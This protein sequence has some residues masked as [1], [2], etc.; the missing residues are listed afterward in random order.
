MPGSVQ[1]V[2]LGCPV[3]CR[4][5]LASYV[6]FDSRFASEALSLGVAECLVSGW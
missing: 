4:K 5:P 3:R 6:R 2:I 1:L